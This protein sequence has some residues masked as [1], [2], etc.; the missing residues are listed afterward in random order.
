MIQYNKI[1]QRMWHCKKASGE[2]LLADFWIIL[3]FALTI[4][5][6]FILFYFI[7]KQ[8]N[9][10]TINDFNNKDASF[11]LDSFLRSSSLIESG[12]T[13]GEIISEDSI[14]GDY[15][16][17]DKIFDYFYSGIDC[18]KGRNIG[19][20]II[21]VQGEHN[22]E[23]TLAVNSKGRNINCHPNDGDDKLSPVQSSS[24]II[25]SITNNKITVT[26][27]IMLQY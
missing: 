18:Y 22:L 13:T 8:S 12:K 21:D 9:L 26:L 6:L 7:R 14:N 20:I 24:A 19:W 11:M 10:N 23:K 4:V 15:S 16:R 17:T 3:F 25:P 1:K 27:K 2:D 5:L